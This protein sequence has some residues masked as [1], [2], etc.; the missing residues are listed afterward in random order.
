MRK[1][2][3]FILI[4]ILLLVA[5]SAIRYLQY[6]QLGGASRQVATAFDPEDVKAVTI[7][8][9]SEFVDEPQAGDGLILLDRAHNNQFTM[10]EIGYLDGRL[11]QRGFEFV[12]YEGGDLAAALRPVPAVQT[13]YRVER[14]PSLVNYRRPTQ[15]PS[16]VPL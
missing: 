8:E 12:P 2:I 7:P 5:P 4:F 1:G 14:H 3:I 13:T 6:Y 10:D 9:A 11:S 15:A 16:V